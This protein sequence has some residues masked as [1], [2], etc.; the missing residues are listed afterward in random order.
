MRVLPRIGSLA[1]AVLSHLVPKRRQ[2]YLFLPLLRDSQRFG[3]NLKP[4]FLRMLEAHPELNPIWMTPDRATHLWMLRHGYPSRYYR[5]FPAWSALRAST[6]LLDSNTGWLAH[7]RFVII[8]LWHGTGFKNI[9]LLDEHGAARANKLRA[10]Y[11]AYDLIIATSEVDRKRKAESFANSNV[12]V[13]GSPRNDSLFRDGKDLDILKTK[14]G[15]HGFSTI[16]LFAPTFRDQGKHVPFSGGFWRRLEAWLEA[17]R[18][19]L[20]VKKHPNDG[21]LDVPRDSNSIIDF[22]D[23]VRDVQDLLPVADVL[24]SD[25]SGIVTDY[26][27]LDRPILFFWHDY[28]DYTRSSRSFYYNLKTV[29]PGPFVDEEND[30]LELLKDRSWFRHPNYEDRFQRSK[31]LFHTFPDGRATERVLDVLLRRAQSLPD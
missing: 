30:L 6:L 21:Q 27:L 12:V 1:M 15:L 13:T 26:M 20:I 5:W 2:G 11:R 7:G 18:A 25:Y 3:G 8:Q 16:I 9:A 24:I 28:D 31:A 10:A 14:L 4:V 23:K 17:S 22:T 19:V 29:L